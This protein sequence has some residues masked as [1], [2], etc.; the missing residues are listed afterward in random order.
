[1]SDELKNIKKLA[2]KAQAAQPWDLKPVLLDLVGAI[3]S[4]MEKQEGGNNGNG[5]N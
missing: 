3:I 4:W 5:T 1:M 2:E